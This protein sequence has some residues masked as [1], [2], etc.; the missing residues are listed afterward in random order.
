LNFKFVDPIDGQALSKAGE[1]K[2]MSIYS[3]VKDLPKCIQN[4]LNSVKY[5]LKDIEINVTD[6]VCLLDGGCEGRKAFA[7]I[8]NLATEE[9]HT[10]YGSWG[11]SNMF[12]NNRVDNDNRNHLLGEGVVVIKGS[13]GM[14]T[15]ARIYIGNKNI[16]PMLPNE[17]LDLLSRKILYIYRALKSAFRAEEIRRIGA[18]DNEINKLIE[19]GYL[20]KDGRGIQITTKGKSE[21]AN[22]LNMP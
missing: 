11:G 14:K 21:I 8:I 19:S 18:T 3:L 16:I 17:Q 1:K 20:K 10:E 4:A 13:I 15:Y 6:T 12:S 9:Y 22:V 5:H 7:I 2:Q